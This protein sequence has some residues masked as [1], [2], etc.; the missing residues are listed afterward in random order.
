MNDSHTPDRTLLAAGAV[1]AILVV[2][3]IVVV[4]TGDRVVDLDPSTPEGVVQQYMNHALDDDEDEALA[5]TT[6]D[7]D[8]CTRMRAEVSYDRESVRIVLGDVDVS[9]DDADVDVTITRSSGDPLDTHQ[10]SEDVTFELVR[11]DGGWKI[12]EAP[13]PF[14]VCEERFLP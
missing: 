13:W 10:W 14:V 11:V 9:G 12:D 2:A 8:D 5:L 6:L 1:V 4:L 7:P 3:A